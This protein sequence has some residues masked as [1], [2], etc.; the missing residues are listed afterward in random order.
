LACPSSSISPSA[1]TLLASRHRAAHSNRASST[2]VSA[3]PRFMQ[4]ITILLVDR[5][6]KQSFA[7]FRQSRYEH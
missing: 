1:R 7:S 6:F 5:S 4:Q 2:A 3:G